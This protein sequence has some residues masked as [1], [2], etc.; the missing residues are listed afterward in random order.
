MS[1]SPIYVVDQL[2]LKEWYDLQKAKT[3]YAENEYLL[4]SWKSQAVQ[5]WEWQ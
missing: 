3:E 5:H 2:Q 4:G 1:V